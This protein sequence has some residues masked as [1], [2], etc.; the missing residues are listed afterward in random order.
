[1]TVAFHF[2]DGTSTTLHVP[3][4]DTFKCR[5]ALYRADGTGM[6]VFGKVG[7]NMKNVLYWE[8]TE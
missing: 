6:V 5:Q 7:V 1:M 8:E 2:V 3:V 4:A